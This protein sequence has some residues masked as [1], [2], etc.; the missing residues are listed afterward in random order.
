MRVLLDE[1]V[2][3]RLRNYLPGHECESAEYAG[4]AG[5]KNGELLDAA[6]SAHFDVLLTVD[7]GLEYEQNLAGRRIAIIIFRSKSIALQDLL[8]HVPACLAV[9]LS[10]KPGEIAKIPDNP[11]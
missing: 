10:I 1:C 5:L 7:R 8:P 3:Q 2:N 11:H 9:L 6:E 4:F